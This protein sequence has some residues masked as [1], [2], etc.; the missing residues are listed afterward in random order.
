MQTDHACNNNNTLSV[1]LKY[2]GVSAVVRQMNELYRYPVTASNNNTDDFPI[3][4]AG[5]L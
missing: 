2:H 3:I 4:N 5:Q 1:G